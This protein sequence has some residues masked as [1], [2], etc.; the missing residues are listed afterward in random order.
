[1]LDGFG[2]AVSGV[3]SLVLWGLLLLSLGVKI[4]VVVDAAR[5]K[6]ATYVAAGKRTK[7]LWLAI[8]GVSLAVQVAVSNP[9]Y[10]LNVI[11][12]VAAVVYLVD[13]RPALRQV[14]GHGGGSSSGPYGPW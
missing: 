1:M 10:F 13:V 11:G 2:A 7:N 3:Q 6:P 12:L 4:F 14:S 9:L 5:H 8:A